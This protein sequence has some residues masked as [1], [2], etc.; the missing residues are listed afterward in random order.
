VHVGVRVEHLQQAERPLG[1]LRHRLAQRV[2]DTL[3]GRVVPLER[4]DYLM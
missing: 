4:C 1:F 2:H 3:R